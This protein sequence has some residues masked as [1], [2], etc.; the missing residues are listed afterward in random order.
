MKEMK[1]VLSE[2]RRNLVDHILK[3]YSI[4]PRIFISEVFDSTS[5]S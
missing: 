2:K 3:E 5:S 1:I 4:M